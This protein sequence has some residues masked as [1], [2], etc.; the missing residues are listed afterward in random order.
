MSQ[1]FIEYTGQ[2]FDEHGNFVNWWTPKSLDEFKK[3]T[4]CFV[5]QYS[6]YSL[7][8]GKVKNQYYKVHYK[9]KYVKGYQLINSI[10]FFLLNLIQL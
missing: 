10:H 2:L 7:D 5:N 8:A 9:L 6:K 4:D 1:I 3:R